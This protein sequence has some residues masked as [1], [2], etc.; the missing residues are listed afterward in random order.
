MGDERDE[1]DD[2]D[3]CAGEAGVEKPLISTDL[4]EGIRRRIAR[5]VWGTGETEAAATAEVLRLEGILDADIRQDWV[6]EW[7]ME[8]V[9]PE[10]GEAL[11]WMRTRPRS[12]Q[13]AMVQFPPSCVV[14]PRV[15]LRIPARGTVGIVAKYIERGDGQILLGVIQHPLGLVCAECSLEAL[16]AVG[17]WRGMTPSWVSG[18]FGWGSA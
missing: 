16:E 18:V 11:V 4:S 8:G 2:F 14:R 5:R 1:E 7:M 17:Y 3:E 12:L 10:D 9:P 13:R 6:I 15:E